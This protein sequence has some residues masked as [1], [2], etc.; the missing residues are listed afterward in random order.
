M[1]SSRR[2]A[3]ICVGIV[4]LL[5]LPAS[6]AFARPAERA[7]VFEG[8]VPR[9]ECGPGSRPETGLQGQ[10]PLADR[11]SGRSSE[12]YT[13]N[14]DLVGHYGGPQ[15]FEG[16]EWQMAWYGHCAYYDTRL[17]GSQSRR[18]TVVLDGSDPER[19]RYSTHLTTPGMSDP[20][21][22]LK[23]NQERGLLAGVFVAD[24]QG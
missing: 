9:A 12:G 24:V 5:T 2:L 18:G 13:C 21:E 20:W 14:L 23:V 3:G 15:G 8:P 7:P 6:V 16:A 4:G 22:S 19:P 1:L 11:E 17:S 10:V